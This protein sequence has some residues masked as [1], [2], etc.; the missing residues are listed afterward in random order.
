MTKSALHFQS[1]FQSSPWPS[2][3]PADLVRLSVLLHLSVHIL[4]MMVKTTL[5]MVKITTIMVAV[6]LMIALLHARIVI[7]TNNHQNKQQRQKEKV[8]LN[9]WSPKYQLQL[10]PFCQHWISPQ[11]KVEFN[12]AYFGL[13]LFHTNSGLS[14]AIV[15]G[16]D[17]LKFSPIPPQPYQTGADLVP[18]LMPGPVDVDGSWKNP[19]LE[20]ALTLSDPTG[21]P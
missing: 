19:N 14:S 17:L 16:L 11:Q 2:S 3:W 12:R 6:I 4:V 1:F 13:N 8:I 10:L 18:R 15:I 7:I 20:F 5:M 9:H 21:P